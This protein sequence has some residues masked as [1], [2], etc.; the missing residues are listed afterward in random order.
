MMGEKKS[1]Q[2]LSWFVISFISL[3]HALLAILL[4]VYL[5]QKGLPSMSMIWVVLVLYFMIG[6]GVTAGY[7]RL[8]SHRAYK[9]N[10]FVE[11]ILLFLGTLAAENSALDW[12]ARHRK[13]HLYVDT[14]KDPY[15]I[16]KGFWYAHL[17]CMFRPL[18]VSVSS[19]PD[20]AKNKL[21]MFQHKYYKWLYLAEN[22]F[23]IVILGYLFNDFFGAFVFGF[24]LRT[25]LIH[26]STFFINSV[27]HCWGSQSYS[28]ESSAVNNLLLA[29]LTIGEGYHNYHHAFASDY[30][31]G[32]R[33]FHFDPTKWFIWTLYKTGMAKKLIVFNKL[34]I[35]KKIVL[36]D[37]KFLL[38]NIKKSLDVRKQVFLV[39]VAEERNKVSQYIEEARI[40]RD[41]YLAGKASKLQ[42]SEIKKLK[43][44]LK[45]RNKVFRK[46]WSH[47]KK[48]IK[49]TY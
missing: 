13:H 15:S 11:F 30:R 9:T 3:Y 42:K 8:Y 25:F 10:A 29:F 21:I 45:V 22:V 35:K 44:V 17:W 32:V 37:S 46:S 43:G 27:A 41:A 28:R 4:G 16:K 39:R 1:V 23:I 34:T 20:L 31:N 5:Y 14:D 38:E 2:K 19:V 24:L 7:H 6:L 47:W 33:W 49:T 26:H 48:F 36:E 12:G 18:P 40:A